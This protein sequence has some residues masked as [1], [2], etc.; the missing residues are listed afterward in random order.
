MR[1]KITYLLLL[2]GFA[3]AYATPVYEYDAPASQGFRSHQM[4]RSGSAYGGTVY[5]PFDN[6]SPSDYSE[7][8]PSYSPAKAPGG[9]RRAE[10]WTP[11]WEDAT[12]G[13]DT[14]QGQEY[15]VG[16]PWILLLFAAAFAGVTAIRRRKRLR[17]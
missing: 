15:P 17:G 10:G 9:P 6:T 3:Y 16:E 13:P 2:L 12:S 1:H 4:M 14:N 5:A 7:A 11:P 8:S